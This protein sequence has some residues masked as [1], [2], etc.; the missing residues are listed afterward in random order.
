MKGVQ[1]MSEKP[2]RM[3][4]HEC[5]CEEVTRDAWAEWDAGAQEWVLGAVFDYAY[6]HKCDHSTHI[7]AVAR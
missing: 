7:E 3:V 1:A 4:C 6:C 2:I 5:G